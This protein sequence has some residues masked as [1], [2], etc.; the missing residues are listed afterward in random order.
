MG[1]TSVISKED[2][3]AGC[4]LGAPL[5]TGWLID[6]IVRP[7]AASS[8]GCS[9]SVAVCLRCSY[10]TGTAVKQSTSTSVVF[11]LWYD[12]RRESPEIGCAKMVLP[13]A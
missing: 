1:Y 6:D 4:P 3:L 7:V 11:T 12:S 5:M 13:P 10:G 9:F 8:N 2:G